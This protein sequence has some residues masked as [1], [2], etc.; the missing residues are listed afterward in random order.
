MRSSLAATV[1]IC[2]WVLFLHHVYT[3]THF[4]RCAAD[5]SAFKKCEGCGVIM[6][7]IAL[8]DMH[9]CGEKRREVKRFN[10]KMNPYHP[11]SSSFRRSYVENK[12]EA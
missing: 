11:L 12:E 1:K 3:L 6:I 9:V 7:V 4:V 10:L 5:G 2:L 8:F